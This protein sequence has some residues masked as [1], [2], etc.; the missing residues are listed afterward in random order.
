MASVFT[1]DS[2][3]SGFVEVCKRHD[4]D[5][6]LKTHQELIIHHILNENDVVG[7]LPTGFGKSLCFYAPI[8]ILN[9]LKSDAI[10]CALV[11][12]PLR[13]L[14]REQVEFLQA[15][16]VAAYW[17]RPDMPDREKKVSRLHSLVPQ[18]GILA[19]TATLTT[20][21][22]DHLKR[23]LSLKPDVK[24]VSQ[25]PDRPNIYLGLC[26]PPRDKF[27]QSLNWLLK[28][29][30]ERGVH[31]ERT[32]IYVKSITNASD[33]YEWFVD[34]IDEDTL[35]DGEPDVENRVVEM[36]HAHLDANSDARVAQRM[37]AVGGTLRVLVATVAF[38]IGVNVPDVRR[39][40]HYGLPDT[41][42]N[43]WQQSG[44]AA[45]DGDNG[46]VIC[47]AFKRSITMNSDP[48]MKRLVDRM[49]AGVCIRH[50]CL[51]AFTVSSDLEDE[52]KIRRKIRRC[53]ITG[54]WGCVRVTCAGVAMYV[55]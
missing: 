36:F 16:N 17:I 15:H 23:T 42:T 3:R 54:V 2:V 43:F 28:E 21:H 6:K 1:V 26:K 37:T 31:T 52:L 27:K 53:A 38:G 18:A 11:I 46:M 14:L 33:I 47:Y 41:L 34:N 12:A 8:L 10:K 13:A 24:I 51:Q 25:L 40:I 30:Q 5:F 48:T 50:H 4:F 35:Y 20:P 9:E 19:L 44:R 7:V 49:D 29:I 22:L 32:I 45:R 39:I 55:K